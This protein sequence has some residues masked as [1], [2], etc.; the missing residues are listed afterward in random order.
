MGS[1]A[2]VLV[3]GGTGGLAELARERLED[4]EALWSRFRPTSEI[5]R[6]NEAGGEPMAISAETMVLMETALEAWR[7]TDGAYDP[8]VLGD[9]LRAGYVTSF[10]VLPA[11]A[12]ALDITLA[13]GAGGI[14]LDR[15]AGTAQLPAGVGFDPGGIG[16]GLAADLVAEDLL[17]AGADGVC[18]NVGGDLRVSG[19]GPDAQDAGWTIGVEHPT[20]AESEVAVLSLHEGGVATSSRLRRSWPSP[21]APG[22][23]SHH[24]IDP[25]TGRPAA[26]GLAAVTV[27]AARAWQAEMLAKAVFLAGPAG[28][29]LLLDDLGAAGLLVTD[30][31]DVLTTERLEDFRVLAAGRAG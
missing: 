14:R 26:S 12:Q 30:G 9:V 29:A 10:D 2:Q 11:V 24:L 27:V 16:K 4:L 7:I 5:S 19:C 8:T 17:A 15:A 13:I 23:R 31:G 18:V 22:G 6:L 3:V 21:T 28:G 1:D 20:D 25:R